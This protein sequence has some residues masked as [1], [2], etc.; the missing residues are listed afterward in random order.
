LYAVSSSTIEFSG[1]EHILVST[2]YRGNG[3]AHEKYI[4]EVRQ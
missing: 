1:H 2:V 4:A 3:E